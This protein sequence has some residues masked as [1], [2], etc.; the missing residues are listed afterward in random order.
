M[1]NDGSLYVCFYV[2]C[3]VSGYVLLYD[4]LS[5]IQGFPD[6]A[7][8]PMQCIFKSC[9]NRHCYI[10]NFSLFRGCTQIS[11]NGLHFSQRAVLLNVTTVHV[12]SPFYPLIQSFVQRSSVSLRPASRNE[13]LCPFKVGVPFYYGRPYFSIRPQSMA[14]TI[15]VTLP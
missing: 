3:M 8:L 1:G 7:L 9:L 10:I 11:P 5:Q 14:R 2:C 12:I 6:S 13:S 4:G 15:A